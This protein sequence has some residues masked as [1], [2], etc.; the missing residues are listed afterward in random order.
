MTVD[1]GYAT[2]PVS[3]TGGLFRMNLPPGYSP[4][5]S[6]SLWNPVGVR[7]FFL[8]LPSVRYATLGFGVQ[9][10]WRRRRLGRGEGQECPP[11]VNSCSGKAGALSVLGE[12][13]ESPSS[14]SSISVLSVVV[15][16][17]DITLARMSH[18]FSTALRYVGTGA[19]FVGFATLQGVDPASL[20]HLLETRTSPRP[21]FARHEF[22]ETC[23]LARG[24]KWRRGIGKMSH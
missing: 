15:Y 4:S 5:W 10:R 1:S 19:D 14:F 23:G 6:S 24:S 18:K 7:N 22:C 8:F 11:S 20:A 13:C 12:F 21:P 17:R 3:T 9:R 16:F 2:Q